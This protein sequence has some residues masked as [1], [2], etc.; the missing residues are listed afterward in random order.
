MWNWL[1]IAANVNARCAEE[2]K[3]ENKNQNNIRNNN[4]IVCNE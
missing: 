4:Q 3:R 1:A 2:Q